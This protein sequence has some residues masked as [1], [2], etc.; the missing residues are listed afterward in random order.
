MFPSSYNKS[1][2][3]KNYFK[4]NIIFNIFLL[5]IFNYYYIYYSENINFT[6]LLS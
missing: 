6:L 2:I 5:V 4:I 1:R 3:K